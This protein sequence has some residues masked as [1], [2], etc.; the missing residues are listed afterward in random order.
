MYF[1]DEQLAT[2]A[3]AL[4]QYSYHLS[5]N[6][7]RGAASEQV[8]ELHNLEQRNTWTLRDTIAAHFKC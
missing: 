5:E 3:M 1:T 7:P 2:I 6:A 4:R 8:I